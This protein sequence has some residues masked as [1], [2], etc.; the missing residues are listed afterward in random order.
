MK[1]RTAR[2]VGAAAFAAA[3]SSLPSAPSAPTPAP[4]PPRRRPLPPTTPAL[5]DAAP[6]TTP[7]RAAELPKCADC[8]ARAGQGLRGNPAR[9]RASRGEEARPERRLLDL[10]R[11]R[12]EAHGG[13]RRRE[14][15]LR[16]SKGL[17][18]S[19]D[20]LA[21]H[22]QT[23]GP[24]RLL[25][26]GRPREHGGRQL[27]DLPLDPQG[28]AEERAPAG[29]GARRALRDL[30]PEPDRVVPE[31]ALRAPARP[32]RHD[33]PR[34]PRPHARRG[35]P[36]KMTV[37]GE[38]PCLSCH[39]DLRGPFVFQHVTGSGGDCLSCHQPHGSNNPNMLLWAR[40]DQLCLS[41]H[42]QTGG[43]KT[44]G[45][46][47]PVVP[48]PHAAAL[49][50]LH[51]VPRRGARLEPLAAASEV[52]AM[53]KTAAALL[54]LDPRRRRRSARRSAALARPGDPGR[55]RARLP[56]RRRVAATTRCTG[57]RSTTARA[58]SCAR[59]TSRRRSRSAAASSTR[60]TSTPPTS[61]P[62][63]PGSCASRPGRTTSSSCA[64]AG[65]RPTSTARC[66]PSPIPFLDDGHRPRP[67][68]LEP[69]AQHL[70]RDARAP[71]RQDRDAAA[72]LHAQHLRRPRHHD[73]PSRRERVPAE[74]AGPLGRPAL[75]RRPRVQLRRHPGRGFT[76]GWRHVRLEVRRDARAGRR[77]RQRHDADPRPDDHGRRDR[78]H[79]EQQ[80][81]HAGHQRLD[82]RA[83]SSDA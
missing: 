63:R 70:R 66:R 76:Q 31:Q 53:T 48:R 51:D 32:R 33:L 1:D 5:R 42:S 19:Q 29:E 7:P 54:R 78:R 17:S 64:S 61:A 73:L 68:D 16:R 79:P 60:C 36:V 67:A 41:C 50:Q 47:P 46:Q 25:R 56:V 30:P 82:H 24:A 14:P 10:P 35:E 12:H 71:A 6:A 26:D 69:H 59:S 18:G 34:L 75:P 58:C 9:A 39:A 40:V 28:R 13:G 62:G 44:Y 3:A 43:P 77:R 4:T 55:R 74:P 22:A 72:R 20:C 21:C 83:P 45:S 49:P 38:L 80:D 65:A 81:Q 52:D 23:P 57:R 2:S 15:D 8:H 37:Q 27:P 11:R